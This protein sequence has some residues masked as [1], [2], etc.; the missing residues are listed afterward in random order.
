MSWY[1]KPSGAYAM[2][3]REGTEN[4]YEIAAYF[5]VAAYTLEATA[6]IIGNI[7]NEGGLNPWRWQSDSY[8]LSGGYGLFQFTPASG[9][10]DGARSLPNYAPNLS[11]ST[12]TPGAN[13][14]DGAAQ[15]RAF[16]TDLLGKWT[17]Y[18]WD[19]WGTGADFQNWN[20]IKR[21]FFDGNPP[22]M[23]QFSKM[24]DVNDAAFTFMVCFERPRYLN[25]SVR[26]AS[27]GRAYQIISGR[28][29]KPTP[30]QR[31]SMPIYFYLRRF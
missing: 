23:A 9:Y 31:K 8:N 29:P 3:S 26:Y 2:S 4:V 12:T 28:P 21:Q 7:D 17:P 24:T 11:T 6:G 13:P 20:R 22:T 30:S 10:I 15:L 16:S 14:N 18:W 27:A 5:N 19:A 1:A 25:P